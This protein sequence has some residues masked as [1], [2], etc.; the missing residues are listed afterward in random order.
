M[1]RAGAALGELLRLIPGLD[2]EFVVSV[3]PYRDPTDLAHVIDG[4]RK[5][6]WE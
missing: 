4:L 1:D 5:A 6:G 3:N 2:R